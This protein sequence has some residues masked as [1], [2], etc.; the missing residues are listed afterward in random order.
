MTAVTDNVLGLLG[1][2][3][4]SGNLAVGE[5][6][7]AGACQ[8][9]RAKAVL[10]AADAGAATGRR[11]EKLAQRGNAPLVRLPYSKGEL[12]WSL[13]RSSCALL[14]PTDLGLAAAL[15]RRLAQRDESLLKLAGQLEEKAGRR[16]ER[17]SNRNKTV[18]AEEK[19]VDVEV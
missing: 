4:R 13:G 18:R 17:R 3:L 6:P 7:V 9:G 8:A 14:A 10:L 11:G 19:P 16:K 15:I 1:L 12:G 5:D 2:A